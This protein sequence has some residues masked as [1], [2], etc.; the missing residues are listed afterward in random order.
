MSGKFEIRDTFYLNGEPFQIISGAVHYFRI[1]PECWED[2]LKK[3]KLMGANTV[4]TPIPRGTCMSR[5]AES[6][7]GTDSAISS[8]SSGRRRSSASG[9]SCA[10]LR[11]SARN[12]SLAVSLRGFSRTE[13]SGCA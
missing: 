11:T 3:L 8:G 1:L 4:E 12:G 9:L 5:N 7:T 10:P 2:R 13:R 6:I